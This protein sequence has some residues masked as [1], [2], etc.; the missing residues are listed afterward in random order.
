MSTNIKKTVTFTDDVIF[1]I[2]IREDK[3]SHTKCISESIYDTIN[4]SKV[5]IRN[6]NRDFDGI[7]TTEMR[8]EIKKK[9]LS[10]M[11]KNLSTHNDINGLIVHVQGDNVDTNGKIPVH[12]FMYDF[13][14]SLIHSFANNKHV[15]FVE[16]GYQ[17]KDPDVV[18]NIHLCIGDNIPPSYENCIW[19]DF[20][21]EKVFNPIHYRPGY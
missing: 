17:E 20:K 2:P 5:F 1:E 19:M 13:L 11:V 7:L 15:T 18:G 6:L 12:Q 16:D 9:Y 14:N 10:P 3:Y 4:V 8:T 21:E